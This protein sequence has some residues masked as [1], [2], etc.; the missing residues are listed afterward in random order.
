MK[1]APPKSVGTPQPTR[2][3]GGFFVCGAGIRARAYFPIKRDAS[4]RRFSAARWLCLTSR[5]NKA[6][7]RSAAQT[8]A[9]MMVIPMIPSKATCF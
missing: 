4:R 7:A 3:R 8:Q 6:N 2:P 1:N 5:M 9:P